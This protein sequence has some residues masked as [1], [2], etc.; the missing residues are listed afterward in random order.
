MANIVIFE[1][2]AKTKMERNNDLY[3]AVLEEVSA[4]IR[5]VY[6]IIEVCITVISEISVLT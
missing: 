3:N 6:S 2:K 1:T 4:I 5:Y